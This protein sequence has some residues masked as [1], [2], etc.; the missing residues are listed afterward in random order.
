[1]ALFEGL[2]TGLTLKYY[3]C[4]YMTH[5]HTEPATPGY[6]LRLC[7]GKWE[8]SPKTDIFVLR[9]SQ[10][11]RLSSSNR[12]V[13]P[14]QMFHIFVV[15]KFV[16]QSLSESNNI[17]QSFRESNPTKPNTKTIVFWLKPN[18]NCFFFLSSNKPAPKCETFG[19][20]VRVRSELD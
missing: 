5:T 1:M 20:V 10:L 4:K 17:D 8:M 16:N 15:W 7:A 18:L 19:R 11:T 3:I 14:N 13:L 6:K 12:R 9:P 2:I